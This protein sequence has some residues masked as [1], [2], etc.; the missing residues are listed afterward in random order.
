MTS[1]SNP[2]TPQP[3]T[4]LVALAA[5]AARIEN[6]LMELAHQ[7][8]GEIDKALD[9]YLDG[10]KTQLA[11]KPDQYKFVM[12]RLKASAALLS[13]KAD[14]FAV[15]AE[16]LEQTADQMKE[17]IKLAMDF[18]GTKA[19]KGKVWEFK[20]SPAAKRLVLDE[21]L[22]KTEGQ[23]LMDAAATVLLAASLYR[24]KSKVADA[25][26]AGKQLH[27]L[28]AAVDV[29]ENLRTEYMDLKLGFTINGP[30]VKEAAEK[31]STVFGAKLE[32]GDALRTS[33][34]KGN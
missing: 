15:A 16:L 25:G 27:E 5:E 14:E 32:G 17:R 19:I 8:G 12:D 23:K 9:A 13:E 2:H 22:V 28:G 29:L 10:I 7:N 3:G 20:I 31:G 34:V 26:G 1:P 30:K 4:G 33:V 24:D 21:D 6:L 18:L 11:E